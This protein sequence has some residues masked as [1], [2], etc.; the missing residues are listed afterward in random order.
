LFRSKV[1]DGTVQFYDT[2]FKIAL[3]KDEPTTAQG[4]DSV[5]EMIVDNLDSFLLPE[6]LRS[7]EYEKSARLTQ[8]DYM[9]TI[10]IDVINN[11]QSISGMISITQYNDKDVDMTNG[12]GNIPDDAQKNFKQL[13]IDGKEIIVFGSDDVSY[14]NYSDITTNYEITL[15]CDFD[16]MVSIAETIS[17]KG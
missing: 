15:F 13:T 3:N 10:Y 6:A 12:Y 11:N 16:T 5:N 4:K 1:S 7:D 17:V 14:I 9:T 8:D 2:F